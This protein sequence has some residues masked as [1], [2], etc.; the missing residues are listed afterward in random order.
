MCTSSSA[1][2][3]TPQSIAER[4]LSDG[5]SRVALWQARFVMFDVI[6]QVELV[7]DARAR[8]EPVDD[9]ATMARLRDAVA[10]ARTWLGSRRPTAP[11]TSPTPPPR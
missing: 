4:A 6:A 10:A 9:E 5:P 7:L 1:S 2:G 3:P 11:P 8:L